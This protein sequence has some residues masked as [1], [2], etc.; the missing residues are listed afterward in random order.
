MREADEHPIE[1]YL[2]ASRSEGAGT[3]RMFSAFLS[4]PGYHCSVRRACMPSASGHQLV[5]S[6]K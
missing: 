4:L 1:P 6:V 3:A 5:P 2:N